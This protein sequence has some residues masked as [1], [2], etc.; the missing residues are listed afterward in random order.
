MVRVNADIVTAASAD[1]LETQET[2]VGPVQDPK[3]DFQ[4]DEACPTLHDI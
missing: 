2:G 3:A 4:A 1:I